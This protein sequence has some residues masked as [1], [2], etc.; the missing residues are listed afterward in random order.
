MESSN[1]QSTMSWTGA[2]RSRGRAKSVDVQLRRPGTNPCNE[3]NQHV[4][5]E[6]ICTEI[7][8]GIEKLPINEN[9]LPEQIH[10]VVNLVPTNK[11][12]ET[13]RNI[14]KTLYKRATEDRIFGIKLASLYSNTA[15]FSIEIGEKKTMRYLLLTTLQN[16][17]IRRNEIKEEN[18]KLF[19]N[20]ISLHGE[21]YHQMACMSGR[22]LRVLEIPL[23]VYWYMLLET[24]TDEDIELLT[25][26]IIIT[27]KGMYNRPEFSKFML[28]IR[29]TLAENT[30]SSTSKELLLLTI[31]L[32]DYY[33]HIIPNILNDYYNSRLDPAVLVYLH[34]R[35][36][37]L[38]INETVMIQKKNNLD[39]EFEKYS[40]STLRPKQQEIVQAENSEEKDNLLS[41]T[42]KKNFRTE[43]T[44][45]RAIRGPGANQNI[46]NESK[47]VTNLI[48]SNPIS[49]NKGGEHDDRFEDAQD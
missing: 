35:N 20:V 24:A 1:N 12:E 38:N 47:P 4:S 17:Y 29:K 9:L 32:S 31:D 23:L 34:R 16:D 43:N 46:Q 2:G 44:I 42:Y 10:E 39:E 6:S 8:T 13:L 22:P 19:R 25:T 36:R 18:V 48:P 3:N 21:L 26:Q 49:K 28:D 37:Q 11:D 41:N 45:P 7:I 40:T 14:F 15:F 30:L 33:F 5:T 27:G